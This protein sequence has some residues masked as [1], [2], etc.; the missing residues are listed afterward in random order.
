VSRI[1]IV[2]DDFEL[3]ETIAATLAD[4]GYTVESASDGRDAFER[5]SR[6]PL[7][8]A[9]LLDLM[10]PNMSGWQFRERQQAIP[11]L[12]AIPTIVM[13]ASHD[14]ESCGDAF[15]AKPLHMDELLGTLA[16][17]LTKISASG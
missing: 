2:E 6:G 8:D 4:H 1:L 10:M 7:P 3:R 16:R 14:A 12:A 13:S 9:I 11:A 15:L 17:F 5:L